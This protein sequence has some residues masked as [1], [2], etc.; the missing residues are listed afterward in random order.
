[1]FGSNWTPCLSTR[2]Q[3]AGCGDRARRGRDRPLARD[4]VRLV[5]ARYGQNVT[6]VESGMPVGQCRR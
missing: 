5:A 3:L 6:A 1:M 4:R 2:R